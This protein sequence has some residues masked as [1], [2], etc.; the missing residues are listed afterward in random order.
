[1][2]RFTIN[3]LKAVHIHFSFS[4]AEFSE[5]RRNELLRVLT[6]LIDRIF[7]TVLEIAE[8]MRTL[9]SKR[10]LFPQ[11]GKAPL[12]W[13]RSFFFQVERKGSYQK[14]NKQTNKE[15][16]IEIN[17]QINLSHR[18]ES[19]PRPP[20]HRARLFPC[21]ALRIPTAHNFT[22]DQRTRITKWRLFLCGWT[23]PQR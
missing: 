21:I 5:Q 14:T 23:M 22:R 17:K 16:K 2:S 7:S 4:F 3:Y 11:V 9:C 13:N 19:N 15:K 10:A 12:L 6:T 8:E 20:E 18:Q 1:M